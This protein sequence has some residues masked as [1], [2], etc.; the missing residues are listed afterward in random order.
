[1]KSFSA[2]SLYLAMRLTHGLAFMTYATYSIVYM[3]TV[4]GLNPFQLVF[5]GTVLEVSYFLLEIP[6]GVVADVYSRRLSILVGYLLVGVGFALTGATTSY[7][8][9]LISQVIWGGGY[10]FL[11]GAIEAWIADE[12]IHSGD[13]VDSA[14]TP[15]IASAA[16]LT[17]SQVYLR[18]SQLYNIGSLVGIGIGALLAQLGIAWPL[19]VG[20][21]IFL[22]LALGVALFMPE[23]GFTRTPASERESWGQ[24]FAVAQR[25]LRVV[26]GQPILLTMLVITAFVGAWSESF[27]R[28]WTKHLIDNFVLPTLGGLDW[29]VWF[30]IIQVVGM[31]LS[32]GLAEWLRRYVDTTMPRRLIG[33]LM[34]MNGLLFLGALLFAGA[35][36]F[37]MALSAFWLVGAMRAGIDPLF[38]GWINQFV[39]SKIRATVLSIHGQSDAIGQ[40]VGGPLIGLL[41]TWST[42][43]M[44]LRV[45]TLLLLPAIGLYA[46][47]FRTQ[48]VLATEETLP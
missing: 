25:G 8:I 34:A 39:D 27:D 36:N 4:V 2:Y 17:L 11:S 47:L 44:A 5:V 45:G 15:T 46:Q 29:V 32:L 12:L 35:G 42:L 38:T 3:V 48:P 10:T 31:L 6:T 37:A 9:I 16:R 20:G 40:V 30:G 24:L 26:R 22:L 14:E 1:M 23:A 13:V 41:G 43:R 18:G 33:A 21:A 7:G 19:L 28:L